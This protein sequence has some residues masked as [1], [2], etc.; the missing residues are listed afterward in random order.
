MLF[1]ELVEEEDSKFM[2]VECLS[3]LN[4]EVSAINGRMI[5]DTPTNVQ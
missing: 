2:S 4:L 3:R 1:P 5:I